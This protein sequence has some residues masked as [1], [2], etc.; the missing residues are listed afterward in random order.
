MGIPRVALPL[1]AASVVWGDVTQCACDPGR[2]A[3]MEAR[4]CGLCREAEKQPEHAG[5]FFLKDINP[6]K[7]NRWLALPR[8][9]WKIQ[10]SLAGMTREQ[11]SRLWTEAIAKARELWGDR[12]ALAVNGDER[13]T[14]CHAHIHIGKL[15][16]G[17]ETPNFLVVNGPAEIPA[18]NDG[19]G[20]WV[21]P[22]GNR[23]H[24]HLGEQLT[25]TVL[26]R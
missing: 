4:E 19:A 24:V 9:H 3:S 16:N 10:H 17:V 7:P 1:L 11:R 8:H 25:E 5:V 2:P 15:L 20:L 13:R 22:A 23:L 12:W 6:R 14:Q 26:L 18:P 21:H